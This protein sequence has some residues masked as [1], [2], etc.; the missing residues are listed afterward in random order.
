MTTPPA[1]YVS[2]TTTKRRRYMWCAWWTGEPTRKPF[3]KP[4]A[5][6]GGARTPEEAKKE[7]ERIAGRLLQVIEPVWARAFIRLQAGLPP[8]VEKKPPRPKPEEPPPEDAKRKK[9]RFV[10]SIPDPGTCPFTILGLPRTA[11]LD[12]INRAFRRLAL[13][14]HPDRGGSARDFI[15]AKWA[16]EEAMAIRHRGAG[17]RQ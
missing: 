17:T 15:R 5:F 9:R 1:G 4:D 7:A 14:T 2:I 13:Q 6:S 12:E 11:S 3:R 8:W 10:P 16:H